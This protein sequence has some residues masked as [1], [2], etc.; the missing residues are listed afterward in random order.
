MNL[1][2][3]WPNPH[4]FLLPSPDCVL[5][6]SRIWRYVI[7]DYLLTVGKRNAR[8]RKHERAGRNVITFAFFFRGDAIHHFRQCVFLTM[9][10][11]SAG[12]NGTVEIQI[13]FCFRTGRLLHTTFLFFPKALC[14]SAAVLSSGCTCTDRKPFTWAVLLPAREIRRRL[15][16]TIHYPINLRGKFPILHLRVFPA[17]NPL[18]IKEAS[19]IQTAQDPRFRT[20]Y[21]FFVQRLKGQWIQRCCVHNA[22]VRK[23]PEPNVC[24]DRK[25]TT[26]ERPKRAQA[27]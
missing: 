3:Q 23:G 5:G 11:K 14:I 20:P 26:P 13:Q 6:P 24:A 22:Y 1:Y 2:S 4:A 18:S 8:H 25:W 9:F 15:Y 21:T 27:L 12:V 10:V 16:G 17:R 7:S 19:L